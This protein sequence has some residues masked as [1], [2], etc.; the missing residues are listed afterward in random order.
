[1][2]NDFVKR[3]INTD[4]ILRFLLFSFFF[5][6]FVLSFLAP[7]IQ[8][9]KGYPAGEEIYSFFS[10]VCHQ[11]PTRCLWVFGLPCA[12]CSRCEFLYL[13][14]AMGALFLRSNKK[15]MIRFIIGFLFIVVAAIDPI[16]Q[17]FKFYE[18]NN[19]I[20]VITGFLGGIGVHY[21]IY[22]FNFRRK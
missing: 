7:F 15:Y 9:F 20:R 19:Y 2:K 14:I 1:M 13:G 6:L 21:V 4:S 5:S 3:I 17:F 12:L 16:L 11:Y 22:P 10:P 18:S 8:H